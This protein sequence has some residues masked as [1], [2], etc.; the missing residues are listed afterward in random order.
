LTYESKSGFFFP[1]AELSEFLKARLLIYNRNMAEESIKTTIE[2]K[3]LNMVYNQGKPNE[4]K[5]LE[6]INLKIYPQ[7]YVIIFGPSGC[8]KSTLLYALA[9]F[10]KPTGGEIIVEGQDINKFNKKEKVEFH[11]RKIGMV[12][13]SFFLISTLKILDNVCLPKVFIGDGLDEREKRGK[14]LLERFGIVEQADKFPVELSG[15]QRQR[16][17]IAR[18][19]LNNPDIIIADEP[20]GN[21]DSKASFNVMSILRELN[22]K[23]K[24]TII[25]VT[26]DPNHLSFGNKVVHMSDGRISKI[27]EVVERKEAVLK[28]ED[29]VLVKKETVAPEIQMLMRSF[30][31]FSPSQLGMLLIPFKAQEYLS[32]I[33][34][35][36]PEEQMDIARRKLQEVISGRVSIEDFEKLLQGEEKDG[37]LNWD[38]R[39][40]KKIVGRM[41]DIMEISKKMETE[42]TE[43][44][45]LMIAKY[46]IDFFKLHF[47]DE[48]RQKFVQL[49]RLRMDNQLSIVELC[50]SLDRPV[51]ERG[52]GLDK[53]T[54]NKLAREVE[55]IMLAKFAA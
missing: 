44:T 43:E 39:I 51:S 27:E 6:D 31:N 53:R 23:D 38:K 24:K 40:V 30:R 19:L 46:V 28:G 20:V 36:V 37:G 11:R 5:A 50:K 35:N 45:A 48:R 2:V 34:F 26:H 10:Q 52:M 41:K 7:E 13:Q 4:S 29:E 42:K 47:T 22:E 25:L 17:A 12:F 33:L 54:A 21:L 14:E 16:V 49:I 15:G 8:G 1:Q 55:I 18:A 3:G 9:G 32:H